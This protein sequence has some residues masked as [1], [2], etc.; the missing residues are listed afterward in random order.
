MKRA[1]T[2]LAMTAC[3]TLAATVAAT[4]W[5]D[6]KQKCPACGAEVAVQEIASYGSY[7]YQWPSKLQL[8]YWPMTDPRVLYFC[9]KCHLSLLMG[10][11]KA[12]PAD[13]LEAVRAAV[14]RL[15]AEQPAL[16]EYWEVPMAYRLPL[17]EAAYTVLGRDDA[18]WARF[19]RMAGYHL[20][21]SGKPELA[22]AARERA[23][24]AAERLIAAKAEAPPLKENLIAKGSMLYLLG[25]KEEALAA[26]QLAKGTPIEGKGFTDEQKKNGNK[27]LD[28]LAE[29]LTAK[30]KAGEPLPP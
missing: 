24:A 15:K 3:L 14:A 27:Y 22:R 30:V 29:E 28:D 4:T 16:K 19:H 8:L 18:F 2:A 1:L 10:D 12:L 21:L 17:A 6:S 25:K 5:G 11:F 9:P 20:E 26:L 23:L 7:V 13:K